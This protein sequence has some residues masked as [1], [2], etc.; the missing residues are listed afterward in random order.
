MIEE[1]DGLV[2]WTIAKLSDT[3]SATVSRYIASNNFKPLDLSIHR[4][5]R[6]SIDNSR[7]I[8][9][10]LLS[11]TQTTIKKKK[12]AFYN[13]K[14]GTGK[15]SICF[16]VSTHIALMGYKVLV[17]D[18]D[19]QGHLSTSCGFPNDDSF[20]TLYDFLVKKI[21]FSDIKKT[22]F[23]GLDCIPSNLSLTRLE[24]ELNQLPKREER[25]SIELAE[26]EKDYDFIFVDTNPTISLVNRNVITF[27]DVINIVCET[28]P[29]SL[30]GLKLL[31]EDLERFYAHMRIQS[32][33]LNII[34]NKYEDRTSSSAEAMTALREY[35]EK[36]IK[37][38]F[39]VRRSEDINIGAK[40]GKPLA[41]FAK[42]NSIALADI[43]EL[44][45][46]LLD[47]YTIKHG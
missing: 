10:G 4:N 18:T 16:Q 38:D 15:T 1:K 25:F 2:Q 6:Y 20:L 32:R 21:K 19:P 8:V 47:K 5:Q 14:G 33:E 45:Q 12:F 41:L 7:K 27:C 39:A 42:K 31:V 40:L 3:S 36:Y 44:V 11:K 17:I 37:L 26:I 9:K 22:I 28:Q 35:Y 30:N 13:F 34:P 23:E 43:I 24:V 29:Y 46:Y